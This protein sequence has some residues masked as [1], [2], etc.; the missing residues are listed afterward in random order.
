METDTA[1]P[2]T[3]AD[4][5]GRAVGVGACV[6][7]EER[8]QLWEGGSGSGGV[9]SALDTWAINLSVLHG[10]ITTTSIQHRDNTASNAATQIP[11]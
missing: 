10:F 9:V 8:W 4:G 6:G 7:S 5:K 2:D 3:K 1:K 11:H